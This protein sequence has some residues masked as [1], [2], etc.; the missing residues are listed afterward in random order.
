MCV[1]KYMCVYNI[2]T[3]LKHRG[4]VCNKGNGLLKLSQEKTQKEFIFSL[5]LKDTKEFG[6]REMEEDFPGRNGYIKKRNVMKII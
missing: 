5:N 2:Y 4:M 3:F 1:Y 6:M